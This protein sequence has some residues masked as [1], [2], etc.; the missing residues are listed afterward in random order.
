MTGDSPDIFLSYSHLD[1]RIVSRIKAILE[2]NGINVRWDQYFEIGDRWER[3]MQDNLRAAD[4]V[5]ICWSANSAK[6]DVVKHEFSIAD[7][8][9]KQVGIALEAGI[10]FPGI[11]GAAHHERYYEWTEANRDER[12]RELTDSIKKIAAKR[13][14]RVS[15]DEILSFVRRVDRG[16][17]VAGVENSIRTFLSARTPACFWLV[18][19]NR[20]EWPEEFIARVGN[21]VIP[22]LLKEKNFISKDN[23][24]AYELEDIG[25]DWPDSY[26]DTKEAV[27][28]IVQKLG[29]K[30]LGMDDPNAQ[31]L[32][33][34]IAAT[35]SVAPTFRLEVSLEGWRP[36]DKAVIRA[37]LKRF[38]EVGFDPVRP[39]YISVFVIAA[40]DS[41]SEKQ[42]S[43]KSSGLFG[44]FAGKTNID[45]I[46]EALTKEMS[47]AHSLPPFAKIKKKDVAAWYSEVNE[48]FGIPDNKKNFFRKRINEPFE[49]V[50][51]PEVHYQTLAD[52]MQDAL[53]HVFHAKERD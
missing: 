22:R 39:K 51:P 34:S 13:K 48:R 24:E 41:E 37:L 29:E 43:G 36:D 46:F 47:S 38:S 42:V 8:E 33:A 3:Q 4:C 32:S 17:Q 26:R 49:Q 18:S 20:S 25:L 10:E 6:S 19:A 5:V 45:E 27:D 53:E 40:Y 15:I 35:D 11:A 14:P 50:D 12:I 1:L 31:D 30:V 52:P 28:Y 44:L 23:D 2:T 9:R 21:Q 16:P 7:W